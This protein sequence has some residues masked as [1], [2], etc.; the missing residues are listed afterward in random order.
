MSFSIPRTK[1]LNIYL[2]IPLFLC[3]HADSVF[4][5]AI[6]YKV[7]N[8]SL[9]MHFDDYPTGYGGPYGYMDSE[10]FWSGAPSNSEDISSAVQYTS[11]SSKLS[12]KVPYSNDISLATYEATSLLS[13]F[14]YA[15]VAPNPVCQH[16]YLAH[17]RIW[18]TL[19][20]PAL[21]DI[22]VILLRVET[23]MIDYLPLQD[24]VSLITLTIP[25]GSTHSAPYDLNGNFTISGTSAG[26]QNTEEE[27]TITLYE[28]QLKEVS[29][30]GDNMG[31]GSFEALTDDWKN[32]TYSA[33]QWVDIDGDGDPSDISGG[34]HTYSVAY[35]KG[36]K[37][38]IGA[39]LKI[40]N[41][42]GGYTVNVRAIGPNGVATPATSAPLSPGSSDE[43]QMPLTETTG[44]LPNAIKFYPR[45]STPF[46][47]NWELSIGGSA[48]TTTFS[49]HHQMYVTLD[50]PDTTHRQESIFFYACRNADG[51]DGSDEQAIVDAIYSEFSDQVV[52]RI[53]VD[54]GEDTVDIDGTAPDGMKYWGSINHLESCQNID[55]FLV[56]GTT[57]CGTWAAYFEHIL[58]ANGISSINTGVNAIMPAYP[59]PDWSLV[60]ANYNSKEGTSAQAIFDLTSGSYKVQNSGFDHTTDDVIFLYTNNSTTTAPAIFSVTDAPNMADE[61]LVSIDLGIGTNPL[62]YP[63]LPGSN[64]PAQGN[65]NARNWFGDHAIIRY[66]SYY[67]DPSYGSPKQSSDILWEKNALEYHG[68]F[69]EGLGSMVFVSARDRTKANFYIDRQDSDGSLDTAL[70]PPSSF[71]P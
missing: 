52:S 19:P 50:N 28:V 9:T 39:T 33:P 13:T 4:A 26:N 41:L 18:A 71:N 70:S 65:L 24:V 37:P 20:L 8:R 15:W 44:A 43:Y 22:K 31:T 32:I 53:D 47:I 27:L 1:W 5:Q 49:T 60:L 56:N 51:M 12:S 62:N 29:F 21:R 16:A 17:K 57:T 34:E 68:V 38:K 59:D 23:R 10:G 66:G 2:F 58:K 55:G 6:S 69:I 35:V 54:T 61:G 42:P 64:S 11:L 36:S 67:Y 14:S 40:P 30:G 48:T 7:M 63:P 46:M 3:A 25:A 45:Y